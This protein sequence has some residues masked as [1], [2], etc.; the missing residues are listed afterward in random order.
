MTI[1]CFL[2]RVLRANFK[3][4]PRGGGGFSLKKE[5]QGEV[6]SLQKEEI[7][8]TADGLVK[9]KA[10]LKELKE[11]EHP[12]L[13]KRVA[14]AR[15][16]G[17]L[18]ENA[19]YS[20]AREELSFVKN[21]IAELEATVLQ[22]KVIKSS[23]GKKTVTLGAKVAVTG[24]GQRQVFTVVGEWEADPKLKKISFNSPLGKALMGKKVG[25]AVEIKAPAGKI[26][27]TIKKID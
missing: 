16:F 8:F 27:Y 7:Y 14:R 15:D 10:T 13:V 6:M 25:E 24:N 22:A 26:I 1:E 9:L 20:D 12:R 17:D 2:G 23:R 19:E 18:S 3:T 11:K 21:R 5:K 4:P